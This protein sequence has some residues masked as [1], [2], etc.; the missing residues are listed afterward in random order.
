M[1]DDNLFSNFSSSKREK[2][3]KKDN[4]YIG[5]KRN[6][7]NQLE[8]PLEDINK[9]QKNEN[10]KIGQ[11]LENIKKEE[12]KNTIDEDNDIIEINEVETLKKEKEYLRNQI[13]K[14]FPEI[15]NELKLLKESQ[16]NT[17]KNENKNEINNKKN[18]SQLKDELKKNMTI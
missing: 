7:E 6:N 4:Q 12:I 16:K 5:K 8:M 18:I 10:N 1:E 13:L 14:V 17:P 2:I 9:N 11:N 3:P 15:D